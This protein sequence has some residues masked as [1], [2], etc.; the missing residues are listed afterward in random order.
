[1]KKGA[2]FQTIFTR[3]KQEDSPFPWRATTADGTRAPKVILSSSEG[4]QP[5]QPAQV[6]VLRSTK[7][8]SPNH[9][10]IEVE[11]LKLLTFQLSDS[12][13]VPEVLQRKLE[14]LLEMG[15]SILLDGPQGSGKTVL[16][17]EVARALGYQY[18]YFNCSAVF[19]ATD[20]MATLQVRATESGG[21]ETVWTPTEIAG[22]LEAARAEPRQRFLVF[23]DE[24]NRCRVMARNG[25]MPALD[26]TRRMFDPLVGRSV[27]IPENI[28]WIAAINNGAQFTGTTTVDPAQL[29][30]FAPL[31]VD[32]P[33]EHEEVRLLGERY[34][35]VPTAL[36]KR[37]VHAAN[38]VR[39]DD[40]LG[41]DLS[42][43]ATDEVTA[44]LAH[45]N[46]ADGGEVLAELLKDSFC[47]RV[48]GRWDDPSSDAG[49]MWA[50]VSKA[51]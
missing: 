27:A 6:R 28:Q 19:E 3:N 32:Y 51:L 42:M 44:L 30:R 13:Y 23:L 35:S 16:S 11:L 33:P 9:G 10:Y 18:V 39:R 2:V 43:R 36:R 20:F 26:S 7:P 34:P 31:K 46:F 22:A 5:G 24:L 14:A 47:G 1:M 37:V 15:R 50:T 48:Q 17:R 4:I 41:V 21:V 25:L 40:T 49:M 29:D 8:R 12:F 38:A 45:P